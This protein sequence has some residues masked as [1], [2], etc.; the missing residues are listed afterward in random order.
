VVAS[1]AEDFTLKIWG[2]PSHA[3]ANRGNFSSE[4]TFSFSDYDQPLALSIH[5]LGFQVAVMLPDRLRIYHITM[6]KVK[7]FYELPLRSP[8][9]VCYS[10]SGEVIAVTSGTS[11]ILLDAWRAELV[12]VFSGHLS[13]INHVIFSEDDQLLLSCG[14]EGAIYGWELG[15]AEKVRSFEHVSK[16]SEYGCLAYDMTRQLVVC[17]TRPDGLLRVI[18][19]TLGNIILE[20]PDEKGRAEHQM[21]STGGTSHFS[22]CYTTLKLAVHLKILLAGT[23]HGSIRVFGWPMAEGDLNPPFAEFP[24]H[25]HSVTA[26]QISNDARTLFSGCSGGALMVTEIECVEDG[27][28]VNKT[29]SALNQ[30]Y[31]S[32]RYRKKRRREKASRS[33]EQ[34]S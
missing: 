18:S 25:G 28:V 12:H 26:M 31:V 8:G 3:E 15:T 6:E 17:C 11:V 27:E 22:V 29:V 7:S 4:L 9:Q 13:G 5:P 21:N 32:Y 16:G 2:Y 23:Q 1:V 30:E 20:L 14:S 19:H 34:D 24:I 10:H 33:G